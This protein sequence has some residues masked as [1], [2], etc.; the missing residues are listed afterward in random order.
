MDEATARLDIR[1]AEAVRKASAQAR[2]QLSDILRK[3]QTKE[4]AARGG[5][6]HQQQQQVIGACMHRHSF[7]LRSSCNHSIRLQNA[8]Q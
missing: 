5:K 1:K 8:S 7:L 2:T 6:G 4:K 3:Q